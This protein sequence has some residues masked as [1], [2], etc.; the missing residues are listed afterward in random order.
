MK[1]LITFILLFCSSSY[2]MDGKY[3][4]ALRYSGKAFLA[5]PSVKK[6]K[7]NLE[8]KMYNYVPMNRT[9]AAIIGSAA[10]SAT[11]GKVSTK[12]FKNLRVKTLGGNLKPKI[13]Y[14]FYDNDTSGS[15]SM[16]WSF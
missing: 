3:K 10:I 15:V 14:N 16:N 13:E 9:A 11:Q 12:S 8:R 2:A 4:R 7:R 6:T 1:I 5:Y